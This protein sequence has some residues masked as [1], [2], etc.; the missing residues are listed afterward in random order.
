MVYWVIRQ[1]QLRTR[2]SQRFLQ[3]RRFSFHVQLSASS[4]L[5]HGLVSVNNAILCSIHVVYGRAYFRDFAIAAK[6]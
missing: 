4:N 1:V 3:M 5:W 2:A 6:T